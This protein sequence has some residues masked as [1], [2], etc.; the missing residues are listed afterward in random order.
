MDEGKSKAMSEC[1]ITTT[2]EKVTSQVSP[3]KRTAPR[4]PLPF[5]PPL[6]RKGEIDKGLGQKKSRKRHLEEHHE[7]SSQH[8]TS[9]REH[10]EL[11]KD[12]LPDESAGPEEFPQGCF[13]SERSAEIDANRNIDDGHQKRE[14]SHQFRKRDALF[15]E[16]NQSDEPASCN[17]ERKD[18]ED[19]FTWQNQSYMLD[20][21]MES[22]GSKSV[23]RPQPLLDE[24]RHFKVS[25]KESHRNY[26]SESLPLKTK[27]DWVMTKSGHSFDKGISRGGQSSLHVDNRPSL[28]ST[29]RDYRAN[30]IKSCDNNTS[31]SDGSLMCPAVSSRDHQVWDRGVL[32]HEPQ[33]QCKQFTPGSSNGIHPQLKFYPPFKTNSQRERSKSCDDSALNSRVP[34]YGHVK[35]DVSSYKTRLM[36]IERPNEHGSRNKLAEYEGVPIYNATKKRCQRSNSVICRGAQKLSNVPKGVGVMSS[37]SSDVLKS[38]YNA[39]KTHVKASC[40]SDPH[41]SLKTSLNSLAHERQMMRPSTE[42]NQD[43]TTGSTK[44]ALQK[45]S[46]SSGE[47]QS[48]GN[49]PLN[50]KNQ[51]LPSNI[52][53]VPL[54]QNQNTG[55]T[56]DLSSDQSQRLNSYSAAKCTSPKDRAISHGTNPLIPRMSGVTSLNELQNRRA[57]LLDEQSKFNT[58]HKSDVS[59]GKGVSL[60]RN[61]PTDAQTTSP[62]EQRTRQPI[63]VHCKSTNTKRH[64]GLPNTANLPCDEHHRQN[65]RRLSTNEPTVVQR[66]KNEAGTDQLRQYQRE[67]V[68]TNRK[69]STSC[70]ENIKTPFCKLETITT[71]KDWD[72]AEERLQRQ[73]TCSESRQT[74]PPLPSVNDFDDMDTECG[75]YAIDHETLPKIVAVHSVV[76]QDEVL[77]EANSSLFSASD[78]KHWSDLLKTLKMKTNVDEDFQGCKPHKILKT[79]HTNSVK[80]RSQVYKVKSDKNVPPPLKNNCKSGQERLIV[81]NKFFGDVKKWTLWKYL[82]SPS[83]ELTIDV[84]SPNKCV[85]VAKTEKKRQIPRKRLSVSELSNKILYTRERIKKE[86]IPWKKKLLFSLEATF[87]KRLR[88]T[89]KETGE[90]ADIFLEEDN[91]KEESTDENVEKEK[92]KIQARKKKFATKGAKPRTIMTKD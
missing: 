9:V 3:A 34:M 87:I 80:R 53:H 15:K 68:S 65:I 62:R 2:G 81:D 36:H 25:N 89:E 60:S 1:E 37:A 4:I 69:L 63:H 27:N 84:N 16:N 77:K 5:P 35:S 33:M 11:E 54:H 29:P 7:G 79:S 61:R 48:V 30:S 83:K 51:S 21:A 88:K 55:P 91:A 50:Q 28:V 44:S 42:A 49:V 45:S 85:E 38:N 76:T 71:S 22:C 10:S 46:I 59:D 75:G 20:I 78:K 52:A 73:S 17:S 47:R 32:K 82:S 39:T 43:G 72:Q 19:N 57:K 13:K 56:H 58:G 18:C 31:V 70:G 74:L 24:T 12:S 8:S 41:K 6:I 26:P 67:E 40:Q 14:T 66:P 90:K 23:Q 92:C 86:S 64:E